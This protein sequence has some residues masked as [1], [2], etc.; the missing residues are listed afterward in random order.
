M[1]SSRIRSLCPATHLAK[2]CWA[3]GRSSRSSGRSRCKPVPDFSHGVVRS[4]KLSGSFCISTLICFVL[5]FSL[6]SFSSSE[7]AIVSSLP[8]RASCSL[9]SLGCMYIYICI[10]YSETWGFCNT[11]TPKVTAE[12][13]HHTHVYLHMQ[14]A[15]TSKT[16]VT[17][18]QLFANMIPK[19]SQPR[20]TWSL[21]FSE[22]SGNI[23]PPALLRRL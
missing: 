18:A 11:S 21:W 15:A 19:K 16:H 1:W 20:V 7:I 5:G 8:N 22:A 3:I 12:C 9:S 4:K 6:S 14:I 10:F 17:V 2:N 23:S 13:I